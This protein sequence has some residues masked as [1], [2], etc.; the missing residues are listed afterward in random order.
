MKWNSYKSLW[1]SAVGRRSLRIRQVS[2]L[3]IIVQT[4][5]LSILMKKT[6]QYGYSV[7]TRPQSCAVRRGIGPSV[8]SRAFCRP[9][10]TFDTSSCQPIKKHKTTFVFYSYRRASTSFLVQFSP[11]LPISLS[12]PPHSP[13]TP[14]APASFSLFL[15]SLFPLHWTHAGWSARYVVLFNMHGPFLL[16]YYCP[17]GGEG[18]FLWPDNGRRRDREHGGHVPF[19]TPRYLSILPPFSP[20]PLSAFQWHPNTVTGEKDLGAFNTPQASKATAIYILLA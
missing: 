20:Y 5:S 1:G 17:T 4:L 19:A 16:L 9:K 6:Q 7:H 3:L 2:R 18:P 14:F 13:P 12:N 11:L 8:V 10:M 15:S